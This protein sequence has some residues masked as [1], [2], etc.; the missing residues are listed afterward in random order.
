MIFNLKIQDYYN[1][2]ALCKDMQR[3]LRSGK[4]KQVITLNPEM[5]VYASKDAFFLKI[6]KKTLLIPD[7]IG[8]SIASRLINGYWLNRH[9]GVDIMEKMI[10]SDLLNGYSFYFFGSSEKSLTHLIKNIKSQYQNHNIKLAGYNPGEIDEIYNLK[11]SEV[12]LRRIQGLLVDYATPEIV[13]K[14]NEAKP[15]ILFVALGSPL[16]E[17]WIYY[18]LPK[19]NTVKLAIGVGGAFDMLSGL[20][21]RAPLFLRQLGLEWLWRLIIEPRRIR[22]IYNAI[23]IFS[24]IV[25]K[26]LWKK[27]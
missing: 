17:K 12:Q 19:L 13:E 3:R 24:W 6:L 16:Q 20:K 14:I 23:L 27:K 21:P 1:W 5:I 22:R 9:P 18:N 7:G 8:I 25:I 4:K 15:D 10:Q 26:N 2:V 11:H